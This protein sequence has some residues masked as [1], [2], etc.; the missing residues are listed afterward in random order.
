LVTEWAEHGNLREYYTNNKD[1]FDLRLKLRMSLDIARGLNFL[2]AVEIVH[3]DIRAENILIT[4]N[5]TAKLANFKL[6][7][8]LNAATLNQKQ[9]LERVRYCAPELLDRAPNYKYD[10]RCEVY[11]FGILLWE[12]AEGK[13]PYKDSND[14]VDIT[15]K[16]R[17]KMYRE[18][19][20]KDSRMPEEFKQLEI[21]G[22]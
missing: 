15:E 14:I 3:R 12:I 8:Y 7:R 4:I 21:E 9:N 11:S 1:Q 16:V 6:S 5:D 20:S 17:N 22:M 13:V 2:R 19:F 10:Q 18:P